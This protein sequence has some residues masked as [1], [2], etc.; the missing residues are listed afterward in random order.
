MTPDDHSNQNPKGIDLPAPTSAPFVCAFGVTL[1]FAGIVT[2]WAVSIVGFVLGLVGAIRWWH[3]VLPDN[4][5]E[6]IPFQDNPPVIEARP[7]AVA[8]LMT[9]ESSH[10][11]RIP[12]EIHP[13]GAGLK[14]GIAGGI[15]M[16][17]IAGLWGW[18]EHDSVWYPV[19]ILGATILSDAQ[20]DDA[21]QLS[22]WHTAAFVFGILIHTFMSLMIGMLYGVILPM[23]P[24][25]RL[26]FSAIA[27]PLMWSGLAWATLEVINPVLN[28]QIN[29]LWFIGS[30]V[31][32]GIACWFVVSRSEQIGTMQN[33]SML[34]RI[35]MDSPNV[36]KIGG[37]E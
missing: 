21:A 22:Q 25:F 10:R 35:G 19:N 29:W 17:I 24:R 1:I 28:Q 30:Q 37:D 2:N 4:R 32:F 33:W 7:G 23:V 36:P 6:C 14:G 16:A 8:H 18:L 31:G 12:M 9:A 20:G 3:E 15:V 27:V 11:A 26:V 5:E 13:Y 34:E